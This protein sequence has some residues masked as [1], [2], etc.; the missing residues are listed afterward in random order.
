MLYHVNIYDTLKYIYDRIYPFH[1]VRKNMQDQMG[2]C[3]KRHLHGLPKGHKH[4]QKGLHKLAEA[5]LNKAS[6]KG[7]QDKEQIFHFLV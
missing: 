3:V 1:I 7:H 5:Q 2:V 4:T 6:C